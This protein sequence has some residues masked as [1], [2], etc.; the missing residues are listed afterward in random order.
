MYCYRSPCF[1]TDPRY[2]SHQSQIGWILGLDK[3]SGL[4]KQGL[5]L[6]DGLI[7]NGFGRR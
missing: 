3:G 5:F 1:Y 7:G 2:Q 6:I 4:G